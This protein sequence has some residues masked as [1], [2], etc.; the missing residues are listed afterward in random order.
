MHSNTAYSSLSGRY[1]GRLLPST[2][3]LFLSL[4]P[5]T[6]NSQQLTHF[7]GYSHTSNTWM[8][9]EVTNRA[10]PIPMKTRPM[11]INPGM[12]IPADSMGCHAGSL[13]CVKAVLS[14]RL[15]DSSFTIFLILLN[16]RLISSA[17]R[18]N[19]NPL[20]QVCYAVQQLWQTYKTHTLIPP[21]ME[22]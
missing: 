8:L 19:S 11:T 10:T 18:Y 17:I 9:R 14:G 20:L 15:V 5:S 13:C 21:H 3:S 12:T 1:N 22:L 7:S 2:H 16:K 6:F 4:K